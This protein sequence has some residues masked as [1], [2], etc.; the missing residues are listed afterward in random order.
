MNYGRDQNWQ[1][2][3][4]CLQRYNSI[5]DRHKFFGKRCRGWGAPCWLSDG[6]F[7]EKK[8]LRSEGMLS[9]YRH[10]T[11]YL[12]FNYKNPFTTLFTSV[13][14]T[15]NNTW[16]NTLY[17]VTYDDVLSSS[18]GILHP[19]TS[20]NVGI[21]YSLGKSIGAINSGVKVFAGYNKNLAVAMSQGVIS[22]CTSD[23]YFISPYIITDVNRKVIFKYSASYRYSLNK[24][25]NSKMDRVNYFT[26][27]ISATFIPVKKLTFTVSFNHYFNDMIESSARSSWFGNVGARYKMKDVDLMLNWTNI[28]N[29]RQFVTYSYNDISSYYSV[30]GLRPAEVLLRVRFKIL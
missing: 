7:T 10:T 18:T 4:M 1:E 19:N 30:Y 20:H 23:S 12:F 15:Y 24:I 8:C 21:N 28:F 5:P 11:G 16:R 26:Q 29:T 14:F 6:E 13:Q 22:D 25:R 2:Y 17:D 3:Q 9:E 27:D